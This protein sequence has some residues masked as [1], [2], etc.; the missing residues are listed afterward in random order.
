[1]LILPLK[2]CSDSPHDY[3]IIFKYHKYLF[4]AIAQIELK[5]ESQ[6]DESA[7]MCGGEKVGLLGEG[8]RR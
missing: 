6:R 3:E 4:R 1:M 2:R 8:C 5:I 7:E